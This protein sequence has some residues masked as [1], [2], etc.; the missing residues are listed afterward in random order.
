[1][2]TTE[3]RSLQIFQLKMDESYQ[4]SVKNEHVLKIVAKFK[5]RAL[6]TF[7]VSQR[8]DGYYLVDG[9]HRYLAM[10]QL[11]LAMT[12]VSCT[13]HTGLSREE[14]ADLCDLKN[15][16]RRMHPID[17]FKVS[18]VA[19]HPEVLSIVKMLDR[20]GLRV[21]STN[22]PGCVM[23]VDALL[24]IQEKRGP[25]VLLETLEVLHA[26]WG[27]EHAAYN[28]VI[29]RTVASVIAAYPARVD[30]ARLVLVLK[31]RSPSELINQLRAAK[32]FGGQNG[33]TDYIVKL[34]NSGKKIGRLGEE[35]AAA[36]E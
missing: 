13:V 23:A 14:E 2:K 32:Q 12:H 27:L 22:S 4:R 9:Q 17:K 30:R 31:A 35:T 11:G 1:M 6:G 19:G 28:K 16:T 36:A 5:P 7:E 3:V 20:F 21:S 15:D 8:E 10:K 26:A 24:T 33:I 18:F 34:Y 25:A 29:L